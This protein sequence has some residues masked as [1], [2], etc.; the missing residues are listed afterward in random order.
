[1]IKNLPV[2]LVTVFLLGACASPSNTPVAIEARATPTVGYQVVGSTKNTFM[3]VVDPETTRNRQG[4]QQIGDYL[5][6][7]LAVH[8]LVL[9]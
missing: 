4:L 1:M 2:F 5:C 6:Q 7:G 9:G 8:G 3:V